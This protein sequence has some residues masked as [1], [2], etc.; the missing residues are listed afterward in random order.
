MGTILYFLG[1]SK[2][3]S[4]NILIRIRFQ[5]SDLKM[6]VYEVLKRER[7]GLEVRLL[8]ILVFIHLVL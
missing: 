5:I 3:Y 4:I 7:I 1:R 8:K 2:M 6:N